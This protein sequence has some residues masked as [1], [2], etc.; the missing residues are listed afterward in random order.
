MG[1]GEEG[2]RHIHFV[3]IHKVPADTALILVFNIRA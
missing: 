3:I 1:G 2:E